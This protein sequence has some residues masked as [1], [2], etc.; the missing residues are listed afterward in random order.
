MDPLQG[1]VIKLRA[2]DTKD[3]HMTMGFVFADTSET[4]GLEIS[5]GVCQLHP[6]LP[7]TT[8]AT[9]VTAK[10]VVDK[11]LLRQTM[12][13]QAMEDGS[14]KIAGNPETV[15]KFFGYFQGPGAEGL[16]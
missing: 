6:S 7:R 5:E 1:M 10:A 12:L 16:S 4:Y 13:S 8:H 3:V 14:L 11:I 15:K 9:V 2:E